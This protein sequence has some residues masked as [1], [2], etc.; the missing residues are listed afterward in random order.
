[1]CQDQ[2]WC[3]VSK[4]VKSFF[5]ILLSIKS[6]VQPE[7]ESH[8]FLTFFGPQ[9]RDILSLGPV[10][11]SHCLEWGE[12]RNNTIGEVSFLRVDSASAWCWTEFNHIT[13]L[14]LTLSI[15][16][17]ESRGQQS[18][19]RAGWVLYMETTWETCVTGFS[20]MTSQTICLSQEKECRLLLGHINPRA[21]RT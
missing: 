17:S 6:G 7:R 19:G 2:R 16:T 11:I 12:R 3:R 8:T 10:R 21:G 1:M 18:L 15:I 5:D 13:G 9:H 4:C 20:D 14:H